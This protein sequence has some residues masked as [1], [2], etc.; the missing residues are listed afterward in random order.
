MKNKVSKKKYKIIFNFSIIYL[1]ILFSSLVI[2]SHTSAATLSLSPSVSTVAT[3][4]IFTEKI[5]VGTAGKFVNNAEGTIQFPTDLLEVVSISKSS[6]IFSLWVEEPSFSNVTGKVTFNGGVPNPGFN[7]VAGTVATIT[8]KA[9]KSG[10]ASIIIADGAVREND[11]LGTD[12]LS[13]KSGSTVNIGVAKK[14]EVPDVVIP[15]IAKNTVPDKPV[16]FSE[17]NTNQEVW[18]SSKSAT[19]S[20][21]VPNSITS[22][23]AT[24]NK[25]ASG[26]PT[27]TYDNSVSQKTLNNIADGKSYFHIRFANAQGYGPTTHYK[28]QIDST[29]PKAFTPTVSNDGY[30]SIVT[31]NAKDT[32]SGI[33]YYSIKIDNLPVI[34]VSS[35]DIVSG[36]Y[37]LPVQNQGSHDL[38]VIA[39]DKAGNHTEASVRFVAPEVNA[40]TIL[41]KPEE[42]KEGETLTI[43]GEVQYPGVEVEV[44]TQFGNNKPVSYKKKSSDYGLYSIV[45]DQINGNGDLSVWAQISFSDT[46]KGR[47]SDISYVKVRSLEVSENL[48]KITSRLIVFLP[49]LILVILILLAIYF[50]FSKFLGM[51]KKLNQDLETTVDDIHQ[52]MMLLKGELYKQ[53]EKIEEVKIDRKLNKKEQEVFK[54]IQLKIDDIDNIIEKKLKKLRK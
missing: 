29:A 36:K 41:V 24:L 11:G 34:K 35:S 30:K 38:V 9:K 8:F 19:F 26:A 43:N 18:Y 37:E 53:L 6:S 10:S 51:K 31:L 52:I 13:S 22:I 12:I 14:V 47:K 16:V 42:I 40:P 49:T 17:T 48:S 33:D 25:I 39:Y 32:T 21:K 20:W 2:P 46:V 5:V 7:G 15:A 54:K 50:G 27:T 28:I 3:G 45:T 4:N 1:F 44:F 23:Q